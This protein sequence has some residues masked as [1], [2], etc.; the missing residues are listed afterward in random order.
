MAIVVGYGNTSF[1]TKETMKQYWNQTNVEDGE[2]T[3]YVPLREENIRDIESMGVSLEKTFYFDITTDHGSTLRVFKLRNSINLVDI[4]DGDVGELKDNEVIL[5]KLFMSDNQIS[6]GDSINIGGKEYKIKANAT[7]PDY[8][9]RVAEISDVGTD[10]QFGIVFVNDDVF[11]R[12]QENYK[13]STVY[14]YTYVINDE[15]DLEET[16]NK[17]FDYLYE[18]EVNVEDI[19]DTYILEKIQNIDLIR[20]NIQAGFT[21]LQEGMQSIILNTNTISTYLEK[22]VSLISNLE[23]AQENILVG[24]EELS[25]NTEETLDNYLTWSY[26]NLYK[27][28]KADE[29]TRIVD[30]VNYHKM[31]FSTA[32]V[33]GILL[34]ILIA[35]I[36]SVFAINNVESDSKIIGTLYA[37]GYR[38]KEILG[39]Y[40]ILPVIIVAV[41]AVIGTFLGFGITSL[42]ITANYSHPTIIITYPVGLIIYGIIM[43]I[44]IAFVI[45]YLVLNK[46]LDKSALEIIRNEHKDNVKENKKEIHVYGKK[47]IR[48][49]QIK[50]FLHE[51]RNNLIM[52]FGISLSIIILMLGVGLYGSLV[53]Y[54]ESIGEDTRFDYMYTLKNPLRE[55]PA[56][57][58]T[59]YTKQ[60][61]MFCSMAGTDM[62]VVLQGVES[63]SNYFKFA[64]RLDDD[65][66][67]VYISDS[68]IVKF[69]YNVGDK[70]VFTDSLTK[71]EYAFTIGGTVSYKNGIYFFMNIDA[72][73][74]YFDAEEGYY[75]TLL[76]T[77]ELND[78][79]K[80]MLISVTTKQSIVD[81]AK[82]WVDDT[83]GTIGM[84]V[85][86][87]IV[88]FI[89]VI[90]LLV[91]NMIDRAKYNVSLMKVLGYRN[92]ETNKIYLGATFYVVLASLVI[93]LPI[94][95]RI[96]DSLIP[97]LNASMK[98][99]M[100][101]YIDPV[102]YI[103]MIILIVISYVIPYLLLK[104]KLAKISVSEI[105]KERE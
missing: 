25:E 4:Q 94:G 64:H 56:N 103:M 95:A 96:M 68:A 77:K 29:N 52:F 92:K 79:D 100:E 46:K 15:S 27:F 102:Y 65:E 67:V 33:A 85:G 37:M 88:I 93:T 101:C 80:N 26:P 53:H 55:Q 3:T 83:T 21:N 54:A 23:K 5:E 59:A 71:K 10:E 49:F 28:N 84:F 44:V 81:T 18:T 30:F 42:C 19:T 41:G 104:I 36:I 47:F 34:A 2:F 58:E 17:L 99:G 40:I 82:S 38:K 69:G 22:N 8:C 12:L 51:I 57:T 1:S 14:N 105:L 87:S 13:D 45:N 97:I 6:I 74:K 7:V 98:S 20:N 16:E 62:P 60:F 73:R 39:Q 48:L 70:I 75:N 32:I 61:S 63:D 89:L 78:I 9:H 11:K 31:F 43:P 66:N 86:M 90:Y 72:M 35:Y 91:K 24:L 76:S 50:R